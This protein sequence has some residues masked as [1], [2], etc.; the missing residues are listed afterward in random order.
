VKGNQDLALGGQVGRGKRPNYHLE[1]C[2]SLDEI[3]G[4]TPNLEAR[5]QGIAEP[6]SDALGR[7]ID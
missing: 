7:L 5:L 6:S 4:E 1:K 2:C 3:V